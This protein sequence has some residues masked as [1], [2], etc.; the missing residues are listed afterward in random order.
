MTYEIAFQ[1]PGTYY[2][3]VR[4]TSDSAD[5]DSVH[6][7]LNGVGVTLAGYGISWGD[8]GEVFVWRGRYNSQDATINIPAAGTYT[9][10]LWMRED[11]I[12]VDR[13]WLSTNSN[14]VA[15]GSTSTGPPESPTVP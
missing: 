8:A 15:E 4:G 12:V 5:D 13:I 11:G 7:G 1:T 2:V 6:V 9:F 3:H 10:N 14:A